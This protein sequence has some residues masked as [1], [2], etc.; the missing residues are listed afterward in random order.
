[1]RNVERETTQP[2]ENQM[3]G[4]TICTA[5]IAAT[6]GFAFGQA[7]TDTNTNSGPS[8]TVANSMTGHLGIG[9]VE[10]FNPEQNYITVQTSHQTQ[11][12]KYVMRGAVRYEDKSGATI[13]PSTVRQGA[14]VSLEFDNNGQVDRVIVVD[15]TGAK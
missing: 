15:A 4:I 9:T 1:M 7:R 12:V 5:V 10:G 2:R 13:S 3:K 8:A 11:P 14:K 6:A